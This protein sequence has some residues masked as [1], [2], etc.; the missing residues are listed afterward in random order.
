MRKKVFVDLHGLAAE[1]QIANETQELG[2]RS[3]RLN[4]SLASRRASRST[5]VVFDEVDVA[6]ALGDCFR[7]AL[8]A[9]FAEVPEMLDAA[10]P[11]IERIHLTCFVVLFRAQDLKTLPSLAAVTQL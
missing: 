11:G 1:R 6:L 3:E 2:L 5:S 4:E 10:R 8:A 9:C 7:G